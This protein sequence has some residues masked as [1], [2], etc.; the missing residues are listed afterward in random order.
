[1]P[2]SCVYYSDHLSPH[3]IYHLIKLVFSPRL[4]TVPVVLFL[5]IFKWLTI[6]KCLSL[7]HLEKALKYYTWQDMGP[8]ITL[9]KSRNSNL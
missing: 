1:M 9:K 5:I 7:Q 2:V 6:K 4:S 3:V 8:S